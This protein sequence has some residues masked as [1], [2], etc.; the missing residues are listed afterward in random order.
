M[1][2]V[3]ISGLISD[4]TVCLKSMSYV[5][6]AALDARVIN[7]SESEVYEGGWLGGGGQSVDYRLVRATCVSLPSPESLS[8]IGAPSHIFRDID[9]L[10]LSARR[11]S[12]AAPPCGP[13]VGR[14]LH[15]HHSSP[16]SYFLTKFGFNIF[17]MP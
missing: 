9:V 4:D 6:A 17:Q 1:V 2:G 12:L 10:V 5:S 14:Y 8:E 7:V 16:S 11:P 13:Q 15:S 3:L